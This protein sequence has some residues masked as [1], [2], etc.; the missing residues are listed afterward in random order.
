MP[1]TGRLPEP[2]ADAVSASP[3]TLVTSACAPVHPSPYAGPFGSGTGP[4]RV[5][6]PWWHVTDE[7][8]RGMGRARRAR[9]IAATAASVAAV[10]G[11]RRGAGCSRLGRHQGGGR[12]GPPRHGSPFDDSPDDNGIY[13]AGRGTPIDVV[14]LGTQ[15]RGD[16]GRRAPRDGRGDHRERGIGAHRPPGRLTN[17]AVVGAESSDLERRLIV[18]ALRLSLESQRLDAQGEARGRE[19]GRRLSSSRGSPR[20]PGSRRRL[21]GSGSCGR[22]RR[23]YV[24]SRG[25]R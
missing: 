22:R 11:S 25:G 6:L 5:A 17:R 8:S 18:A 23:A 12:A 3:T 10:R 24:R 19:R 16:G 9:K 20:P 4:P 1:S 14:V 13:G 2:R 15:R 21:C 7:E